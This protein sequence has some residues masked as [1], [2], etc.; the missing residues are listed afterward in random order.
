MAVIVS[1]PRIF[2]GWGMFAPE[3]PYDDGRFIVDGRTPDG[4][5]LDPLTGAEPQFDPHAERGYGHDQLWCDFS[6][7]IRFPGHA[8]NRQHL[9]DYL[10]NLHR[11]R[12]KPED[13]L[14]AFDVWWVHD[15][16]PRPGEKR[17]PP[18]RP[19]RLVSHGVVRDSGAG[20]W[21]SGGQRR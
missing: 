12:G 15:R 14:V 21:L 8:G 18:L 4:R 20:A 5:K 3:P 9:R 2:Q 11:Y 6:N 16:S 1:Y 13:Q 7:R 17:G 10:L 19:E